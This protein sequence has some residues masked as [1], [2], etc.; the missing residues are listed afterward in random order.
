MNRVIKILMMSS[1]LLVA[2]TQT[3]QAQTAPAPI[4]AF[5]CNMQEGKG[6]KDL[7]PVADRFSKWADKNNP[8]YSAWILTPRFGM[9]SQLPQMIWLGSTP[10]GAEFGKGADAWAKGGKDIQDAFDKVVD[11]SAGHVL[12][13][14]VE[15]LA[16]DGNPGDG[17]VMFTQCE[18]EDGKTTADAAKLQGA[19]AAELRKMG[20]KNSS[21]MF[22]PMI[23]GGDLDYDYLGV[24]TY[25]SQA[26]FFAAYDM[27]VT[28]GVGAKAMAMYKGVADCGDPTPTV[29]DVKTVRLAN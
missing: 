28:G 29:W 5:Y 1:A 27:W 11:C 4:E 7:M 6:M 3:A 25:P 10:T 16:P 20:A 26:D 12:A 18:L 17:V 8:T 22:V 2:W 9:G 24:S 15:V 19:M 23:G 13:S 21:W 14:S